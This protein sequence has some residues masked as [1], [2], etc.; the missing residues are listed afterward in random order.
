MAVELVSL[1]GVM[2]SPEEWAFPYPDDEM[3]EA[4]TKGMA[5]S[6]ALLLGRETYEQMAAFWPEQPGG[7]PM[8]DY[9][10]HR[11]Q[12]RRLD[13]ASGSR[14]E[15]LDAHQGQRRGGNHRTQA[16]TGQEHHD[17]RERHPRADAAA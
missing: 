12:V 16:A 6:D 7:T 4:N 15:Q 1:D 9:I 2:E 8:V 3:N 14:V 13:D 5:A 10:K 11:A 17:P